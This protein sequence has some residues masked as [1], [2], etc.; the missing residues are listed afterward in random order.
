MADDESLAIDDGHPSR[1][2]IERRAE[3]TRGLARLLVQPGA[4]DGEREL[5]RQPLK[6]ARVRLREVRRAIEHAQQAD[7]AFRSQERSRDRLFDL[8]RRSRPFVDAREARGV[9]H[10][11]RPTLKHRLAT[12]AL[13]NGNVEALNR[14]RRSFRG[15]DMQVLATTQGHGG[16]ISTEDCSRVPER[17]AKDVCQS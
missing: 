3:F 11:Q 17:E 4:H 7:W 16:A 2:G 15:H 9:V 8:R 12:R 13:G 5:R 6:H 1:D 10:D 14:I